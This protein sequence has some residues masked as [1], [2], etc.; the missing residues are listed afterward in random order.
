MSGS[1]FINA[2]C[3]VKFSYKDLPK[4]ATGNVCILLHVPDMQILVH[5]CKCD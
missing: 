1:K 5:V 2:E 4:N 3:T